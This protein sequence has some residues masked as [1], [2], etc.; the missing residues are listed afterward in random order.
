M[1]G[2]YARARGGRRAVVPA[3][4][5]VYL[6]TQLLRLYDAEADFQ[7][8]VGRHLRPMWLTLV[9]SGLLDRAIPGWRGATFAAD[10]ALLAEVERKARASYPQLAALY[11]REVAKEQ[12]GQARDPALCSYVEALTRF[13]R[14]RMRLVADGQPAP[15]ALA[16]VHTTIEGF[17][18]HVYNPLQRLRY[19]STLEIRVFESFAL[20]A[21]ISGIA[22]PTDATKSDE[23]RNTPSLPTSVSLASMFDDS[24]ARRGGPGKVVEGVIP[25][26]PLG[27]EGWEPL[28]ETA[29]RLV[30]DEIERIR[31]DYERSVRFAN[32]ARLRKDRYRLHQLMDFLLH[33]RP[34]AKKAEREHLR[35][36]ARVLVLDLPPFP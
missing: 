31:L 29:C 4:E 32:S 19:F 16:A 35:E 22:N 11:E 25:G 8:A 2:E 28:T 14:D 12:A 15:W 5:Q 30:R 27:F 36:I 21:L 9:R 17:T 24:R 3:L 20:T 34:I 26:G 18:G 7:A 6:R 33:N 23:S 10:P 1:V 13:V